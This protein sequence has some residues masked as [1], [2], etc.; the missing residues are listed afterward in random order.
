[1]GSP[2]NN[3]RLNIVLQWISSEHPHKIDGV[4][5]LEINTKISE[6]N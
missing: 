2:T 6:R 5:F 1:M 3:A 4:K